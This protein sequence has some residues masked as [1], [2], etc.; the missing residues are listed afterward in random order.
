MKNIKRWF[1]G[2]KKMAQELE[3]K[4]A[5][6]CLNNFWDLIH[7]QGMYYASMA[8]AYNLYETT[9]PL[10]D[11]VDTISTPVKS[12]EPCV[13]DKDWELID[14]HPL[15]S[16]LKKPNRNQS[17]R[18]FI[19]ECAINK[20]VTNNMF[21]V[22]TGNINREALEIYP[23]KSSYVTVNGLD[24][25]SQ[26][27]YQ[28]SA[29]NKNRVFNGI[30]TFD[31]KSKAFINT[32]YRE[33]VH[34]KGYCKNAGDEIFALPLMNSILKEIE[35]ANGSSVHNASLLKNGVTLSGIFKLATSDKKAIEEFRQQVSTYFSGNSN[36]GKYIA[37]HADN[38][39]FKPINATNKDM[40]IL[41]LKGDSEDAVYRKYNIPQP[42]YKTGAQTY[43]NYSTAKVSLYDDAVF[44]LVDD[45]FDKLEEM[46][47][48]RKMLDAN[49]NLSYSQNDISALQMRTANW[50]K[51]LSSVGVL[52]DNEIRTELG[53]DPYDGGDV[54][55]KPMGMNPV[56]GIDIEDDSVDAETPVKKMNF[57]NRMKK[58]GCTKSEA[59]ELWKKTKQES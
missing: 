22:V 12:I 43:D 11:A 27:I 13:F 16:L 50:A 40:Q 19:F 47:K 39:D 4:S 59:I 32:D 23:I 31:S 57:I 8:M 14:D 49:A 52:T 15:L 17:W 28:I 3:A 26:P 55:Y 18:E 25:F 9:S 46:F 44:P 30:Y 53:Y 24:V 7:Q 34:L 5:E 35:I 56:S 20:L 1:G 38:I 10:A 37:A 48:R 54:V 45:I 41:E 21:L 42:L 51:E 2:G 36:A 58:F 33:L 6:P 29:A